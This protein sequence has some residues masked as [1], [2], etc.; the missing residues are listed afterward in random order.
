MDHV[1]MLFCFFVSIFNGYTT[2]WTFATVE[3][4]TY[5]VKNNA[6]ITLICH[7]KFQGGAPNVEHSWIFH[8]KIL[9]K[10]NDI[11]A[12]GPIMYNVKYKMNSNANGHVYT[13]AIP[14]PVQTDEGKYW[15]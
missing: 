9:T 10:N 2:A 7:T 13:L 14:N 3:T 11:L 6:S 15:C 8:G 12:I 4:V 5:D 1:L